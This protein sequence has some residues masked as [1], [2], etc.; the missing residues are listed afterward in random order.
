M[1]S[2]YGFS[3][4]KSHGQAF[5]DQSDSPRNLHCCKSV[6]W[7]IHVNWCW[8]LGEYDVLPYCR[9]EF[10]FP[11]ERIVCRKVE[12][13]VIYRIVFL[14]SFSFL[15]LSS[16]TGDSTTEH[17]HDAC[18][19]TP[20]WKLSRQGLDFLQRI[21]IIKSAEVF[22]HAIAQTHIV[23]RLASKDAVLI[24]LHQ[25]CLRFQGVFTILP[26]QTPIVPG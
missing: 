20:V 6:T 7:V 8:R 24:C 9:V 19:D 18:Q 13:N 12:S 10:F 26:C 17:C 11:G 22:E 4:H 23:S 16:T 2:G 3:N 5:V 15:C 21:D 25:G 14:D 1:L